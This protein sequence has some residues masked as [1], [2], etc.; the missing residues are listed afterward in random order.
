MTFRDAAYKI[1]K[2]RSPFWMEIEDIIEHVEQTGLFRSKAKP[3]HKVN[4]LYG[5]L[6]K[7][8]QANDWRFERHPQHGRR[9]R[10][11]S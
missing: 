6:I 7:A 4:S 1:L 8:V 11:R 5:N 2:D 9:F 3:E 10:S